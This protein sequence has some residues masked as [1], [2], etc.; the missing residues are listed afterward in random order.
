MMTISLKRGFLILPPAKYRIDCFKQK[1]SREILS[2][3][4]I[5]EFF[6]VQYLQDLNQ[7]LHGFANWFMPTLLVGDFS[8]F[9][10]DYFGLKK[11]TIADGKRIS[12]KHIWIFRDRFY[13][14]KKP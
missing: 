2:N 12:L 4:L 6:G 9:W 1:F 13:Q 3:W 7:K 11:N 14:W 8:H 5:T 10:N